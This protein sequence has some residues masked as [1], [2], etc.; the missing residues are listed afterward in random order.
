[1]PITY[2]SLIAKNEKVLLCE[3][4]VN[5]SMDRRVHLLIDHMVKGKSSD[6]IEIEN[7]YVVAYSRT[8]RLIFT[9]IALKDENTRIKRCM[10]QLVNEMIK[11]FGSFD[12]MIPKEIHRLCLQSRTELKINKIIDDVNT[13]LYD[14]K[15][16]ITGMN[17][18]MQEIK[19]DMQENIKNI[20][21]NN[22]DLDQLLLT[23]QKIKS[24]AIDYK[25]NAHQLEVQTR[26]LKP[27]M[28]YVLISALVLLIVYT[29][30]ALVRCGS[31]SLF[32]ED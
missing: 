27:W 12:Q 6:G 16:L 5:E 24:H 21:K 10:E 14:N 4:T 18:D 1:M 23:S 17:S 15:G 20:V 26:C 7:G 2:C 29:V 30:F 13:S 11:E 8:K 28:V 22:E 25:D 9:C 19:H 31:M 32:C 3:S